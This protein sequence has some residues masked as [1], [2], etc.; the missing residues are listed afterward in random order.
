MLAYEE[1]YDRADEYARLSRST[2]AVETSKLVDFIVLELETHYLRPPNDEEMAQILK[3]NEERGM[4]R[5]MGSI[6]C[7]HWRQRQCPRGLAGQCQDYK[8]R[9]S[10]VM[11]TVRDETSTCG[12]SSSGAP[13]ARVI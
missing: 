9:R 13:A 11:E 1:T 10:I 5:C 7:S 2:S 8:C 4:L 3:R 12:T 6:D